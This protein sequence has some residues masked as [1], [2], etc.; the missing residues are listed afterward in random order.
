MLTGT[1]SS[2]GTQANALTRLL[3]SPGAELVE[4][5]GL[6][7][8]DTEIFLEGYRFVR[9]RFDNCSIR[10]NSGD[11]EIDHSVI[12]ESCKVIFGNSLIRVMRLFFNA[13]RTQPHTWMKPWLP[14]DHGDGTISI[15][16]EPIKK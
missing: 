9:C 13:W 6:Y 10:L 3:Q 8:R 11:F 5:T 4:I 14:I 1:R 2:N 15:V 16:T 7:F 12:D